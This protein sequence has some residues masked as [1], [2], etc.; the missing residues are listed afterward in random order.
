VRA[1]TTADILLIY[2]GY[3]Q[4]K[5]DSTVEEGIIKCEGII[6]RHFSFP[7]VTEKTCFA[8]FFRIGHANPCKTQ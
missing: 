1:K 8:G 2:L 4:M 6:C 5:L 3:T 7:D